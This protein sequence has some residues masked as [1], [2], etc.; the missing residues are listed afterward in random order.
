[1][2]DLKLTTK[3]YMNAAQ[4]TGPVGAAVKLLLWNRPGDLAEKIGA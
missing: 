1:M 3:T 4:L 2:L